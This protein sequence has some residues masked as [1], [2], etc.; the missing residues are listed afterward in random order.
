MEIFSGFILMMF[1]SGARC[2]EFTPIESMVE[3]LQ[4]KKK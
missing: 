4:G 3:C 1:M 2:I